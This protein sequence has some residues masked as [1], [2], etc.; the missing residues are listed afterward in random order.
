MAH[1]HLESQPLDE[2]QG[3]KNNQKDGQLW[4]TIAANALA[5]Q[6]TKRKRKREER[7]RYIYIPNPNPNYEGFG[8]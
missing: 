3:N 6:S 4:R 8:R 7:D 1:F 2:D 5:E